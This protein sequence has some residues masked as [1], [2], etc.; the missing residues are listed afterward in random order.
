MN[1]EENLDF[2]NYRFSKSSFVSNFLEKAIIFE[3][4]SLG[5]LRFLVAKIVTEHL[6]ITVSNNR[7]LWLKVFGLV[8]LGF[9]FLVS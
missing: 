5:F 4:V 1:F 7:Q 6:C 9:C 3:V 2:V 8:R